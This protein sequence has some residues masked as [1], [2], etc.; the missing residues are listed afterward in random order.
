ME[1]TKTG[2]GT[3]WAHDLIG[4]AIW[5]YMP[6]LV[7]F[8]EHLVCLWSAIW[9]ILLEQITMHTFGSSGLL[10]VACR[11]KAWVWGCGRNLDSCS[12]LCFLVRHA[13]S[14]NPARSSG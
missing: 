11:N 3:V 13:F 8:W 2:E 12:C 1:K 4:I 14:E 9:L 10:L 5:D 7:E 6:D